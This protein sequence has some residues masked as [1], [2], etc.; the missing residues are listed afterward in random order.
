MQTPTAQP[1]SHDKTIFER[2]LDTFF[3]QNIEKYS[4]VTISALV[5]NIALI[6]P[7]LLE[8]L[9]VGI[10]STPCLRGRIFTTKNPHQKQTN[11]THVPVSDPTTLNITVQ[12]HPELKATTPK[13]PPVT[14]GIKTMTDDNFDL[15]IKNMHKQLDELKQ[16][17]DK[18]EQELDTKINREIDRRFAVMLHKIKSARDRKFG[19]DC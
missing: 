10:L 16:R 13:Y 4:L 1:H 12:Y 9:V 5:L 3:P 2:Y 15:R 8:L 17:L 7:V 14:S 19:P 11:P 6:V 18:L